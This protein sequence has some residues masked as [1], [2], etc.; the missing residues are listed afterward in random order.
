MISFKIINIGFNYLTDKSFSV[1]FGYL[2]GKKNC[3]VSF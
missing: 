3:S 2:K 1:Q